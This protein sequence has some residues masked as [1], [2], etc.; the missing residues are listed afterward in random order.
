MMVVQGLKH[1]A[2]HTIKHDVFD[3]KCFI[4]L[5]LKFSTSGC[6]QK[7]KKTEYDAAGILKGTVMVYFNL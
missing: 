7:K 2:S 5:V 1:V 4:M 3:D 6:L